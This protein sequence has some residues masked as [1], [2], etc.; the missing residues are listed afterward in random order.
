MPKYFVPTALPARVRAA[1]LAGDDYG[2]TA[3]PDWRTI[4]WA[5]HL[6][7]VEID[8]SPVN[9]VDIGVGRRA[10]RSC[11]STGSAASGR[12]GSRTCRARLRSGA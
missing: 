4:D 9:Y 7:Q 3:Q 8:G 5:S 11:S 6:H 10:S 2:V 12:T 1:R